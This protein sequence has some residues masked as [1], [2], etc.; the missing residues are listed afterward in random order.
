MSMK[1][2][3]L[4]VMAVQISGCVPG[5]PGYVYMRES[6]GEGDYVEAEQNRRIKVLEASAALESAKLTSQAE[7]ERAKGVAE[8]N[9]IIGDSLR[10]NEA[11]LRWLWIDGLRDSA[12]DKDAPTIIYVPTEGGMPILEAG[13]ATRGKADAP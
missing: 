3:V 9:K 8:A 2:F 12:L 5:C 13:R 7:V 4:M 1:R 6:A 10:N 11:Y